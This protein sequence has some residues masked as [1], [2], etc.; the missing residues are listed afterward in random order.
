MDVTRN[1]HEETRMYEYRHKKG[2][3]KLEG[4]RPFQTKV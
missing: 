3:G 1:T 4:K 2:A